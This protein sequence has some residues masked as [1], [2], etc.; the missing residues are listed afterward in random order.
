MPDGPVLIGYDGSESADRAVAEAGALLGPRTALVAVVWEAG[1]AYETLAVATIPAAP[2]DYGAAAVADQAMEDVAR[3]TAERG[4]ER[5]RA[6]G[7]DA[8]G[9]AVADMGGVG[10]TLLRLAE[11]RGAAALVVGARGLGGLQRLVLGSTS[12]HVVEQSPCPVI[13]IPPHPPA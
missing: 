2:I 7:F 8:E 9:V 6:A 4:V 5:A 10:T 3:R 13:V 11:E 12:R 1:M